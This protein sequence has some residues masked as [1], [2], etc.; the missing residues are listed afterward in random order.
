MS[1]TKNQNAM[2]DNAI[3]K[4]RESEGGGGGSSIVYYESES[5]SLPYEQ[6]TKMLGLASIFG[7]YIWNSIV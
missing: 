5:V 4:E 3:N 1:L 7:Y 6:K 2:P